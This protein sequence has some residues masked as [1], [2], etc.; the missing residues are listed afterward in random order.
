MKRALCGIGLATFL[1]VLH[2]TLRALGL[3]SHTSAI[4]GMPIHAWSLPIAALYLLAYLGAVVLAPILAMA[5]VVEIAVLTARR[6]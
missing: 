1:V 5:S 2:G 6:P 3:A 4:A